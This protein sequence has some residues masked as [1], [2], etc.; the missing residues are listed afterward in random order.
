MQK[1]ELPD[2][3]QQRLQAL[4]KLG[5]LDTAAEERFDRL[6]RMA[7]VLFSVP[8]ALVTLVD[9]KRQWFKSRQGLDVCET[10][11]DISFCG[12]A[13]LQHDIFEV[14]DAS[15]DERFAD[16]PLV[17]G[18]PHIRFYAGA[19][20]LSADGY[21]L[22]T[23]CI[24]DSKPRVL[25]LQQKQTFRDLADVVAAELNA[26]QQ[27]EINAALAQ[28]QHLTNV[29]TRAQEKFINEGDRR[30]A[31]D[32]LLADVLA[33]TSSEYGFI[34]EV[35]QQADGAPY[36][37]TYAITDIA[38]NDDTR[39]FYAANAPKGMEFFNLKSLFGT[40]LTSGKPVI[41]NDPYHDPRRG[42][43]PEGHPVMNAFLGL[44][45]HHG[46]KLVAML[47]LANRLGG[48]TQQLITF[49]SPLLVT[50]GQLIVAAQL[51][52][53]HSEHK[54]TL[55]RLSRVASQ[56]TNGV[57]ITDMAGRV[58]WVNEGCT[59]ITGFS[60]EELYGRKPGDVLQGP[61]TDPE[62]LVQMRQALAAN[63][64]FQVD[65]I[66]YT[67]DAKPYW[68]R[69]Q[70]NPLYD[71]N[72]VQQ[73]F[74]AIESDI[75]AQKQADA[76]LRDT[77]Q[78]LEGILEN[79]PSMIFLKDA[80][81][82]RF[83]FL[84]RAGECLLGHNRATLI[85]R[86]DYDFFSASQADVFTAK[87]MAVLAQTDVVD[88]PEEEIDTPQGIRFLHTQKVALRD[89]QGKAQYLLGISEDITERKHLQRL[90]NEFI[91]TVSH[92]LRTPL[93]AIMGALELISVA[94]TKDLS[95]P[96]RNMLEI[97]YNNSKRLALL[98]NDLLDMEKLL[99]G[100]LAFNLQ[101]VA[102]QPQLAEAL[103]ANQSYADKFGVQ[104]VLLD[105]EQAAWV[106]IDTGRFQQVMANLLSNAIKFSP[107]GAE[108]VVSGRCLNDVVR[109][110][111]S[112]CGP[113]ISD[114]FKGR[115]FHK[116]SQADAS[117]SRQ[118]GGTGLGLAIT[119]EL[120]E[121]MGAS[122]SFVSIPGRG[123]TFYVDLPLKEHC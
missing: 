1:P 17:T 14:C 8:I 15:I 97:A 84:N 21:S 76:E 87:D 7:S 33:L 100:K 106:E 77:T 91:A 95:A 79:V 53:Q 82:L 109:V 123:A 16:N 70:C 11:R 48:Y 60:L 39:A 34:G 63:Q 27:H 78:L 56:T 90:Q 59:R 117:D 6:T 111:V 32:A 73:G 64:P 28:S 58:T 55:L 67:K 31:F 54:R 96:M 51:Q 13:I 5:I 45:I 25:T 118:R 98:V 49:L 94:G 66:N 61:D 65:I 71:E 2:N 57:I 74:M 35:L 86:N 99:A 46:T 24:I 88:I 47:G 50:I 62:T 23:L 107:K 9:N 26:V 41:A 52:L 3:E 69:I 85:G 12:H 104:L 110:Q 89:E 92:E 116:F 68:I 44:P 10:S 93:T 105:A 20:L 119:Q 4:H 102:L 19:P 115:I 114:E 122:I 40:A 22:G 120:V 43:L 81:D 108:V 113:G 36:L 103:K 83:K 80:G 30:T 18:A 42:G 38:W 37:K 112:D 121:R 75:T 101:H 72:D 29:I